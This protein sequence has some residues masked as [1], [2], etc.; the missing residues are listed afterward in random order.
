MTKTIGE[1]NHVEL[2]N[3]IAEIIDDVDCKDGTTT[4]FYPRDIGPE[5]MVVEDWKPS[6][7][8]RDFTDVKREIERRGMSWQVSYDPD[9]EMYWFMVRGKHR[10]WCMDKSECRAGC[11]AFLRAIGKGRSG[12]EDDL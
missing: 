2:D 9:N 6:L 12:D 1:M 7:D 10:G 8:A 11:V 5:K 4:V 3:A